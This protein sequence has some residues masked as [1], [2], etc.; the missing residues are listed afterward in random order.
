MVARQG[1]APCI[2]VWK[3]LADGP[4][5]VSLNTYARKAG[6]PTE[7]SRKRELSPPSL[8]ELRRATFALSVAAG[9]GWNPVR[10]WASQALQVS[11]PR[12]DVRFANRSAPASAALQTAAKVAVR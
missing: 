5:R 2:P 3:V 9:E 11:G 4:Q 6:L 8:E 7:A 1:N 10:E 12:S